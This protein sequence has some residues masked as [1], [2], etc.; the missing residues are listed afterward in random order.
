MQGSTFNGTM[1]T[2]NDFTVSGGTGVSLTKVLTVGNNLV[3]TG[4]FST[5]FTTTD[6]VNVAGDLYAQGG[7]ASTLFGDD[8]IVTGV[9]ATGN[10]SSMTVSGSSCFGSMEHGTNFAPTSG[11]GLNLIFNGPS[12]T[13]TVNLDNNSIVTGGSTLDY[14]DVTILS[15]SICGRTDENDFKPGPAQVDLTTCNIVLPIT[16]SYFKVQNI[17]GGFIFSWQTLLEENNDFFTLEYSIDGTNYQSLAHIEGA[18]NSFEKLDYDYVESNLSIRST[19]VYFRLK[20][21]DFDG[22]FDYST[23]VPVSADDV[24]LLNSFYLVPNPV[25]DKG[26]LKLL[27]FDKGKIYEG[28][29]Y[30]SMTLNSEINFT[31][32]NGEATLDFSKLTSGIY[33][34]RINGM[35]EFLKVAVH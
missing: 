18:G 20:Q 12:K 8:L 2:T 34:I 5:T 35:S 6:S 7:G 29:V 30:N 1:T 25:D 17:N 31:V 32:E 21:T 28:K 9:L 15:G 13:T 26:V 22:Q 4:G 33:F 16:L 19:V 3:L 27:Q 14:T 10:G 24:T 11:G 23:V